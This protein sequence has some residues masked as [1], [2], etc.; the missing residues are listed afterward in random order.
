MRKWELV[1]SRFNLRKRL[2]SRYEKFRDL[3]MQALIWKQTYQYF[4]KKKE[5]IS[6]NLFLILSQS[7]YLQELNQHYPLM[8]LYIQRTNLKIQYFRDRVYTRV[9]GQY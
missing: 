2:D 6:K 5:I 8:K 9:T 7:K 4:P 1:I 3:P